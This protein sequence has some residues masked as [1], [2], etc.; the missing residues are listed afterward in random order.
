MDEE[1]KDAPLTRVFQ[2]KIVVMGRRRRGRK[3]KKRVE[4]RTGLFGYEKN[5]EKWPACQRNYKQSTLDLAKLR[6]LKGGGA[7]GPK[8]FLC[9]SERTAGKTPGKEAEGKQGAKPMGVKNKSLRAVGSD[10]CHSACGGYPRINPKR[11][12][13]GWN[14]RKS[15][16]AKA[17]K[18]KG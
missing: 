15:V 17:G 3:Q 5:S 8:E 1:K 10:M 6:L 4:G 7:G 9:H 18:K 13:G 14:R 16:P 12:T 11:L 2:S